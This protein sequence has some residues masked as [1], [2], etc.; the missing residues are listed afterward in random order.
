MNWLGKLVGGAAGLVLGGPVGAALGVLAGHLLDDKL[1]REAENS[2]PRPPQRRNAAGT[3]AYARNARE[4][5]PQRRVHHVED[6]TIE[7]EPV[8]F[9]ETGGEGPQVSDPGAVAD[10]FFQTTFEVMGCIAK[11]DGR[12][13]EQDIRAARAVMDEFKLEPAQLERA[14]KAFNLGKQ[15]EYDWSRAIMALRRACAG[16]PDMLH[17]FLEIQIRTAI[18]GSDLQGAS[19][20]L[21]NRIA[22]MLGVGGLEFTR[23]ETVLEPPLKVAAS[24]AGLPAPERPGIATTSMPIEAPRHVTTLNSAS[25]RAADLSNRAGN[26]CSACRACSLGWIQVRSYGGRGALN[27]CSPSSS[28]S[29]DTCVRLVKR[30]D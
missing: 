25:V 29:P 7:V 17:N 4:A 15:P 6:G 9:N 24:I 5:A 18:G 20:P 8:E 21:L 26:C 13:S 3:E 23:L 12:V 1:T 16:R 14:I 2:K 28:S 22:A 11:S 10:R 19:R 30:L 27:K